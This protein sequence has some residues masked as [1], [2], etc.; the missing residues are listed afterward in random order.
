MR[1]YVN[2]FKSSFINL[3]VTYTNG[4][5]HCIYDALTYFTIIAMT[6]DGKGGA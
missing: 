5:I 6:K 4:L 3:V 1:K 2:F